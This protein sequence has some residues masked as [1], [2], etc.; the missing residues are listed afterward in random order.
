MK[1]VK[2]LNIRNGKTGV[3]QQVTEN[4][5]LV[6]MDDGESKEI[7]SVTFERWYK[8]LEEVSEATESTPE[9]PAEETEAEDTLKLTGQPLTA[10][11]N[12]IANEAEK[13]EEEAPQEEVVTAEE[14][15]AEAEEVAETTQEEAE[16][17]PEAPAEETPAPEAPKAKKSSGKK[18]KKKDAEKAPKAKGPSAKERAKEFFAELLTAVKKVEPDYTRVGAR[19]RNYVSFPAG[20]SGIKYKMYLKDNTLLHS[21]Y[22]FGEQAVTDQLFNAMMKYRPEIEAKLPEYS[23]T[24]EATE[25]NKHRKI[26]AEFT[27]VDKEELIDWGVK[28]VQRFKEVFAEY[29][30]KVTHDLEKVATA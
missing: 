10:E 18:D 20:C 25:E 9:A 12:E 15:P 21:L 22:F 27:S 13:E 7:K 14:A 30:E 26:Y 23:L 1:E 16:Q 6:K 3:A 11:L 19:E 17:A 2:V 4:L 5:W 24:W 28:A 29:I 8:I